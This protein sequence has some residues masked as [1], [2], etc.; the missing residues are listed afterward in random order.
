MLKKLFFLASC[1]IFCLFPAVIP[2]GSSAT[3]LPPKKTKKQ[4]TLS[5]HFITQTGS[6][7][8]KRETG[9]LLE[10]WEVVHLDS[11]LPGCCQ[12]TACWWCRRA[13]AVLQRGNRQ[14]LGGAREPLCN[15]V[16]KHPHTLT[17]W[18]KKQKKHLG[19]AAPSPT[20]APAQVCGGEVDFF[21]F[22]KRNT[23]N[24][25]VTLGISVVG[26]RYTAE[27]LLASRVPDLRVKGTIK[28]Q[29]IGEKRSV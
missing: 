9:C 11:A 3:S 2:D 19:S 8:A 24:E 21:F 22:F 26:V 10:G 5:L 28:Q 14:L 13:G 27:S 17:K 25:K 12:R 15:A 1:R 6:S 29:L 20:A 23:Q 7:L 18:K 16:A 4:K